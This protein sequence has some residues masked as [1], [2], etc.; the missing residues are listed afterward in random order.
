M[1]LL[2][3]FAVHPRES[4]DPYNYYNTS[5]GKTAP[6]DNRGLPRT[7]FKK[8]GNTTVRLIGSAN[9]DLARASAIDTFY[10]QHRVIIAIRAGNP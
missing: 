3:L 10:P 6:Y 7:Q 4:G 9:L 2:C 1:S 5:S 8:S